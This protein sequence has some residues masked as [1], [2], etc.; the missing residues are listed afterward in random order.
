MLLSENC[1][2][3]S[4]EA[5]GRKTENIL[6]IRFDPVSPE[7]EMVDN[8]EGGKHRQREEIKSKT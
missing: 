5:E 2:N 1:V 7:S 3:Q 4:V 6:T 8:Q